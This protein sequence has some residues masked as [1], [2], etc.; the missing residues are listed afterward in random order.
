MKEILTFYNNCTIIPPYPALKFCTAP[1]WR[2]K[3]EVVSRC[4]VGAD[5]WLC[6][7]QSESSL[8][9]GL[10]YPLWQKSVFWEYLHMEKI[11]FRGKEMN[12]I[13]ELKR[14]RDLFAGRQNNNM[15][16]FHN[17]RKILKINFVDR[18]VKIL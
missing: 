7:R 4:C 12:K 17:N 11:F 6:R 18:S 14:V 8:L 5:G 16:V 9:T 10:F 15:P 1:T 3:F 2:D 13:M